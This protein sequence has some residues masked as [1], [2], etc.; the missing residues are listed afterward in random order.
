MDDVREP[1][2]IGGRM[3]MPLLMLLAGLAFLFTGIRQLPNI[4]DE[5]LTLVGADRIL[6]GEVPFK[7]FWHTHPPGYIWL[8]AG[9]FRLTGESIIVLRA[10]DSLLKVLLALSVWR[11]AARLGLGRAAGAAFVVALLWLGWFGLYGYAGVPALLCGLES[12]ALVVRSLAA[13]KPRHAHIQLAGAGLAAGVGTLFRLDFGFYTVAAAA[14]TLVL[15]HSM[16]Q[17]L[18]GRERLR[19]A[20]RA[21]VLFGAGVGV[22]VLLALVVLFGQGAPVSRLIDTLIIYPVVTFP[23]VRRLPAPDL[24]WDT[25]AFYVPAWLGILGL[26]RGILLL[27]RGARES[28]P[29]LGWCGLSLLLLAAMPHARTRADIVHQLPV[30]LPSVALAAAWCHELFRRGVWWR[31]FA[32]LLVPIFALTYLALPARSWLGPV[33]VPSER[34]H[35]LTRAAGVDLRPDQAAAVRAVRTS[36]APGDFVF[37][38]NGRNDRTLVNDAL[39]YFLLG[40][41]YPTFFHNLLPGLTTRETVQREMV[42]G[43]RAHGVRYIVLCTAFDEGVEPNASGDAGSSVLDAYIHRAY[44]LSATIGQYQIWARR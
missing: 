21:L 1:P 40:R 42:S 25:L 31:A 41:R 14:S 13:S 18:P 7:D 15:A 12:L 19:R 23:E 30:L 10:L 32:A 17:G 37:V 9:L 34:D 24:A 35:G 33:P 36:T 16:P 43:L 2:P 29:V 4:Y 3:V 38:G 27:K 26:A 20:F 44:V 5:G 22:P 6:L 11:W 8:A 28:A 39:F